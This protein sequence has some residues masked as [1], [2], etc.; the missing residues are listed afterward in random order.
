MKNFYEVKLS[1]SDVRDLV[2]GSED[3]LVRLALQAL[4]ACELEV[5]KLQDQLREAREAATAAHI[6]SESA[7]QYIESTIV[8][9][10]DW[11][12]DDDS[13]NEG[14]RAALDDIKANCPGIFLPHPD[15]IGGP[16]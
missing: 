10:K 1:P 8:S 13:K 3:P 7:K 12:P 6:A 4:D 16:A 5:M 14:Y 9:A 15:C 2:A 11:Y